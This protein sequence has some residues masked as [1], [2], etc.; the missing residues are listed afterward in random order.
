MRY[1]AFLL[2]L[3]VF[4]FPT[5]LSAQ[6]TPSPEIFVRA[7]IVKLWDDEGNLG[8]GPSIAGGVG[9]RFAHG[10]GVEALVERHTN[11]RHFDSGV[12]FDSSVVGVMARVAKYLGQSSAQ[13]YFGGGIGMTRVKTHSDFPGFGPND[14]TTTSATIAGFTGVR[15]AVGRRAFVRPEFELSRAGE[16]L[17]IGG[18]AAAGFGW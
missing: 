18:S 17:R 11:D 1:P 2:G 7:G 3:G 5:L 6:T 10:I 12:R 15:F 14:R 8:V 4:C 13:P 9:V 16:H